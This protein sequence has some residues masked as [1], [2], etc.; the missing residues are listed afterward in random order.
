MALGMV[1]VHAFFLAAQLH[2]STLERT[3]FEMSL[4]HPTD[5]V[6]LLAVDEVSDSD[7]PPGIFKA[8]VASIFTNNAEQTFDAKVV[9]PAIEMAIR[10]VNRKFSS[11]IRFDHVARISNEGCDRNMIGGLAAQLYYTHNVSA[12]IGPGCEIALDHV[13]RMAAFWNVPSY[14]A[15]GIDERFVRKD[16]YSTLTR[17]SY[18]V[19]RI[20]LFLLK[21]L[22]EFTWHHV[23]ILVDE[24][25]TTDANTAISLE[26]L[27]ASQKLMGESGENHEVYPEKVLFNGSD[28]MELISKKMRVAKDKAR[29]FLILCKADILRRVLLAGHQLGMNDG[30]FIFVNVNLLGDAPGNNL[31]KVLNEDYDNN[32]IKVKEMFNHVMVVSAMVPETD[33]FKRIFRNDLIAFMTANMRKYGLTEIVR[34]VCL[35]LCLSGFQDEITPVVAAFYDC[36]MLYALCLNETLADRG[37]PFDGRAIVRN[38]WNRSLTGAEQS[39]INFIG[40]L[41]L[42]NNGDREADYILQ[43]WRDPRLGFQAVAR[44]LGTIRKYDMILGREFIFPRGSPL[45]VP[46]CGFRGDHPDCRDNFSRNLIISLTSGFSAIVLFSV[47]LAVIIIRKVKY[48][49]QLADTWWKIS[50]EDLIFPDKNVSKSRSS[51]PSQGD[52]IATRSSASRSNF[53]S[54]SNV[55]TLNNLNLSGISVA[56]YKQ[57]RVAV[58][59]LEMK[60]IHINRKLL[61]EMK[62]VHDLTHDNL[63][64]FIGICPDEP[65]LVTVTELCMRGSL[66]DMLENES[67][68]ID[69]LFRYSIISDLVEGIFFL[70]NSTI[71]LHGRLKS[72]KCV[73]DS[74]FVVKLTD[75][76]MPSLAEQIPEP[77]TKNLRTYF[78]T[79]PEILRSRDPRLNGT[80][81]GDIYSF[82]I[83]LQEVITR[84]GPFESIERLGRAKANLEPEEILDRVKM[85]AVPPFRPE[86]SADEC[87]QELLRLMKHCWA[88][89]PNDRPQISE[90]RHKIKKITKGMS[91]RNFFDNLLQR[92][93]QYANNLESIVEEKTQSLIEEKKRTDELLYQ[94]LPKYVADELMKGSH[95]QPESFSEVTI[96]F[97]DIV[98]FTNLSSESSPLQVVQ[99]LNDLYTMFDA[100]IEQHD[101]YKVETIGDAYL[102]ASGVPQPNGNEH[103]REIAR[104]A[105][106]LRDNLTTFKIRHLPQ[107]KLQLRIGIHSGP[108]VAGVVGLK[109]PKYC[110][111]GDAVNT[112]SRMETTGEP[113]KIHISKRSKDILDIFGTFISTLRG[114]VQVKGKGVMTT[115]W[116][117]SEIG[118]GKKTGN[119]QIDQL[120]AEV[121]PDLESESPVTPENINQ[122]SKIINT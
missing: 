113:M 118:R 28:S 96:F 35:K 24:S 85:G 32:I 82:A 50:Y 100:I 16:I 122:I 117:E 99:L 5:Q 3:A 55:S 119:P 8:T 77:D 25:S 9:V 45:D 63:V 107:R 111:F 31:T 67:I 37:S 84:C 13:A 112:A 115:Y 110:L 23:V 46:R 98:G 33:R 62:E 44:F 86:V 26:K 40:N 51:L 59:P 34:K 94:L 65:N 75:F 90:I 108:C 73:I 74:R 41:T 57:I 42:D 121:R 95:V 7:P 116:L 78:W 56:T 93:E 12:F 68:N 92:M 20:G 106:M 54:T 58:K 70:H 36:V 39:S 91:S 71:G 101:V 120:M 97:S 43:V 21:I 18:S 14:T 88:E 38:F 105:L 102:V 83:I 27:L 104:M 66:R 47:I 53:K 6:A 17:M 60:K 19:D 1:L 48:E 52:S 61:M 89:N 22:K 81:Q 10:E 109:M 49:S 15:G 69:W 11:T 114:D 76:G 72:T 87:P 103:V 30:E 4:N 80:K 29:I 79:A 2:K 64:R